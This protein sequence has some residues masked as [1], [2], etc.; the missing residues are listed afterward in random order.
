MSNPYD[1]P[2]VPLEAA[3]E[4][5][6]PLWRRAVALAIRLVSY[7]L[8]IFV[9]M[10]SLSAMLEI[11]KPIRAQHEWI[12]LM[13]LFLSIASASLILWVAGAVAK[14]IAPG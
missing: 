10:L 12:I 5:R 8:S 14:R 4:S 7:L 13:P 6:P 3:P 2:L 1:A 9:A 11:I